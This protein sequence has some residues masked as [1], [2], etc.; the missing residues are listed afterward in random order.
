MKT[1]LFDSKQ[2]ALDYMA[3]IQDHHS[4]VQDPSQSVIKD[5]ICPTPDGSGWMLNISDDEAA[6]IQ[7]Q[8]QPT[9]GKSSQLMGIDQQ[10]APADPADAWKDIGNGQIVDSVTPPDEG[11]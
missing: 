1:I 2:D 10:S 8:S 11:E 9:M 6:E 7:G 5:S 4:A 3:K